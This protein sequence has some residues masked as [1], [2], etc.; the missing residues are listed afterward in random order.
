MKDKKFFINKLLDYPDQDVRR[1]T[2]LINPDSDNILCTC[3]KIDKDDFWFK[4]DSQQKSNVIVTTLSMETVFQTINNLI[5]GNR[6]YN[7][8][9]EQV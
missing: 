1:W 6:V 8:L 9:K 3:Y 4:F 7:Q 5:E 2:I